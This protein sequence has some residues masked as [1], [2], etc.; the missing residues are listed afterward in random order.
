[1]TRYKNIFNPDSKKCLTLSAKDIIFCQGRTHKGER[2]ECET[3]VY[4]AAQS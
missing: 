2:Y 1:M 3:G 4:Q